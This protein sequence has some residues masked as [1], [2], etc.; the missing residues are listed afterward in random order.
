[1]MVG[2]GFLF[3][4]NYV[5]GE[6]GMGGFFFVVFDEVDVLFDEVNI[7]CFIVFLMCFVEWGM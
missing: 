7:C 6:E 3:V 5:G 1:M 4:F 2:F